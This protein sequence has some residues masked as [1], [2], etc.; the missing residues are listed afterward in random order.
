MKEGKIVRHWDLGPELGPVTPVRKLWVGGTEQ[1]RD[2]NSCRASTLR[3]SGQTGHHM[4]DYIVD[5]LNTMSSA[6]ILAEG[7]WD[8]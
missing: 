3:D 4:T 7:V 8:L 5:L 1:Y 6:G 2:G